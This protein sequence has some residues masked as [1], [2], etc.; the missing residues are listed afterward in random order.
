MES[1]DQL[2]WRDTYFVLFQQSNRPTLT[3]VEAAITHS[4]KRLKLE[5][6][7]RKDAIAK[8]AE[9]SAGMRKAA[10]G[11]RLPGAP[12]PGLTMRGLKQPEVPAELARRVKAS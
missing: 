3:Q 5:K 1:D 6:L 4:S 7:A 10:A 9:L 2:E 12:D 8:L 11:F